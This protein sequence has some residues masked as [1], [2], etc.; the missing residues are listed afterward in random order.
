MDRGQ[1]RPF[2][3]HAPV[4]DL[5]AAAGTF[6]S[7]QSVAPSDDEVGWIAVPEHVRLTRDHFVARI[8]GRSMEPTIP[9]DSYALFRVDRGGSRE[10]KLVLVWHRGCTDPAVGGEFSVKKYQSEK[11][12]SVD[13]SWSHREIRL[14][15]LNQDP[16]YKELVFG[17]DSEGD[18]RIIREFLFLL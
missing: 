15:P 11:V 16:A 18:L 1:A 13:G 14:K 4:Y 17:P 6:G 2:E 8:S 5:V 7:D 9:D 3:R 12:R 10:G